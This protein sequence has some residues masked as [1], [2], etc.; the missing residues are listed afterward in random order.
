[1]GSYS[2]GR[3]NCCFF[4]CAWQASLSLRVESKRHSSWEA[5]FTT[6][7]VLTRSI[8]KKLVRI[9]AAATTAINEAVIQPQ[10]VEEFRSPRFP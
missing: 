10:F 3:H 4:P 7:G 1:M 6:R 8:Q 2:D 5:R 9:I